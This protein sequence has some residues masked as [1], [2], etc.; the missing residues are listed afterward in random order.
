MIENNQY[1]KKSLK[2]IEKKNPDWNELA[3]DCI[4]FAN[5]SGGKII[6]GIEDDDNMPPIDQKIEERLISTIRKN[7]EQRTVNL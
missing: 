2:L 1:E 3:K 7:I 4:S 5:A 6:I